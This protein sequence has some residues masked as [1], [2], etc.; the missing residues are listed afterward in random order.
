MNMN[1][2]KNKNKMFRVAVLGATGAVGREI[3]A[4]LDERR[5]PASEVIALAS[6]R[7]EGT[8]VSFGKRR[9]AVQV[10]RPEAFEGIDIVLA[11]AGSAVARKLLPAAVERGAIC[12]DN[13]SAFRMDA[14]VPLVVPEVNPEAV[15]SHGGIIANPNCST[16]QLVVAIKA[17]HDAAR[18]LRIVV[19]TYQSVSGAGQKGIEE[20][21]K[22]SIALFNQK[23]YD[24]SAHE[25]R[26]AFNCVPHIGPFG[27]D[28]YT[29][30]ELKLLY[31]TR[32]IMADE[33]IEVC[34]TAV[35]VPV[36]AGHGESINLQ[37]ERPLSADEARELLAA[38]PGVTVIDDPARKKYPMQMDCAEKDDVFVGRI[39]ID[40]SVPH[41]LALWVVSD[42]LRKGAATNAV[43]I[44]ELVV[45]MERHRAEA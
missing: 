17:L 15:A 23:P 27:E 40:R 18:I 20:L 16:I 11:S 30:E 7:S 35:R 2:N 41:G 6:A 42:N 38:A 22:Q 5:F 37:F 1:K 3:L 28:G 36:F 9:L 13:S 19:S 34:P 8:E 43:Q 26:I 39:R 33:S 24:V 10:A 31:E 4:I 45:A 25:A 32:K 14:D 12:V 29:Q 44:A 21:S